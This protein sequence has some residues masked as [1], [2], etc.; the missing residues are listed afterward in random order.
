MFVA[1]V[2]LIVMVPVGISNC[3]VP[4]KY[5]IKLPSPQS[6]SHISNP[7]KPTVIPQAATRLRGSATIYNGANGAPNATSRKLTFLLKLI[8][9]KL[10]D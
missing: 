7:P 6:T 2:P 3:G 9:G 4:G 1:V 10:P 5:A 8:M